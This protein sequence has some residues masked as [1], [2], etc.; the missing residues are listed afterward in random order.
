MKPD[1]RALLILVSKVHGGANKPNQHTGKDIP[2]L[3]AI[4][5]RIGM[6]PKRANGIGLKWTDKNWWNY[7]VT[8]RS[9]WLTPE[10]YNESI[11]ESLKG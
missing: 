6:H 4:G 8:V 9:G 7:G 2:F 5:E 11:K 1:E 10:G 3:D